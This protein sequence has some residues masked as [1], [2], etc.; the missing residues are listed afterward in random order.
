MSVW[1][2]VFGP[3]VG[4]CHI[5]YCGCIPGI[6]SLLHYNQYTVNHYER[7]VL[8]RIWP[9]GPADSRT[10]T[11]VS[12][13]VYGPWRSYPGGKSKEGHT[14]TMIGIFYCAVHI[15]YV[16]CRNLQEKNIIK[17]EE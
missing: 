8:R 2:G 9:K 12:V 5:K 1:L 11:N 6:Q 15:T 10:G 4:H 17:R 3:G 7:I 16:L 14:T 13:V